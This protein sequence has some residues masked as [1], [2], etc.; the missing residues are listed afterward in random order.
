MTP[1]EQLDAVLARYA[2]LPRVRTAVLSMLG[3]S[4]TTD[5]QLVVAHVEESES[6]LAV[7]VL[8][9]GWF[10]VYETNT[11]GDELMVCIPLERIRRVVEERPG[12]VTAR[13]LVEIDAD[14]TVTTRTPDSSSELTTAAF[15]EMRQDGCALLAA[16]L[17]AYLN[18]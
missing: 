4:D 1:T 10:G 13:V 17:R 11:D 3:V 9:I 18:Q 7:Y 2:H 12:G 8:A 5:A 15:Y 6:V 16:N 14:R